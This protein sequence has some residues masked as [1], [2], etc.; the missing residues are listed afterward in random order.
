MSYEKVYDLIRE[1][2]TT[3]GRYTTY[4]SFEIEAL[5]RNLLQA[6]WND[7]VG[8]EAEK[9]YKK[10]TSEWFNYIRDGFSCASKAAIEVRSAYAVLNTTKS[11]VQRAFA[12]IDKVSTEVKT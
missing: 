8:A 4:H 7:G 5:D 6:Q 1:C 10:I 12:I 9:S 3:L 2:D 11:E